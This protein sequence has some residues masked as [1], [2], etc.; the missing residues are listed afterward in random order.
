MEARGLERLAKVRS[1]KVAAD[2]ENKLRESQNRVTKDW[3]RESEKQGACDV[4][5]YERLQAQTKE[6]D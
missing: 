5:F 3:A 1:S 6:I 4:P 2:V